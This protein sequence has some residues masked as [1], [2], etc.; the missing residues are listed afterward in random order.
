MMDILALNHSPAYSNKNL[1]P[2]EA[3][4]GVVSSV[5]SIPMTEKAMKELVER[6]WVTEKKNAKENPH[7]GFPGTRIQ[8]E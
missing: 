5:N 8:E 7:P 6:T 4:H 3:L 2:F 1:M